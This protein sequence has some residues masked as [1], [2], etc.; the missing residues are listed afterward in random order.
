MIKDRIKW[1]AFDGLCEL[2]EQ[3]FIDLKQ[4]WVLEFFCPRDGTITQCFIKQ[5]EAVKEYHYRYRH[6]YMDD[7]GPPNLYTA[8]RPEQGAVW[9]WERL[10]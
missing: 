4:F 7:V 3:E 5:G 1:A 10:T 6:H 2:T 9:Q 8:K